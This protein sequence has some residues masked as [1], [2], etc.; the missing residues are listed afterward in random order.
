MA[1]TSTITVR[2][3]ASIA[4]KVAALAEA[5]DRSRNWVVEDALKR[6]LDLQAWQVEGIKAAQRSLEDGEGIP[7]EQVMAELDAIVEE[8]SEQVEPN[9]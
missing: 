5:M 2:T 9:M 8:Q 3:S 7:H 1:D 6:Y 4:Q